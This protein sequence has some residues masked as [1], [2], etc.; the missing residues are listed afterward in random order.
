[1]GPN[2]LRFTE[3]CWVRDGELLFYSGRLRTGLQLVCLSVRGPKNQ[4]LLSNLLKFTRRWKYSKLG[5]CSI[6]WGRAR[7]CL[8][9]TLVESYITGIKLLSREIRFCTCSSRSS[10]ANVRGELVILGVGTLAKKGAW[11]RFFILGWNTSNLS[12]KVCW[13]YHSVALSRQI[14]L[15]KRG[16]TEAL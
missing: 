16:G 15:F 13:C 10:S 3:K 4:V 6:R 1:M 12:S 8:L 14:T 5:D 7:A 2:P 9:D 11:G